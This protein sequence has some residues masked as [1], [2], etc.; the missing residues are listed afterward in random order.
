MA[1]GAQLV[2]EIVG[3]EPYEYFPMGDHIV[4]APGVCR[5]RPTFRYTRLDVSHVV[6]EVARGRSLDDVATAYSLSREAVSEAVLLAAEA[7][8]QQAE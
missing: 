1:T 3:G 7:I 5:G 6:R 2:T 4:R 8:H